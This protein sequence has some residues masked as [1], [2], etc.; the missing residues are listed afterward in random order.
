MNKIKRNQHITWKLKH[1]DHYKHWENTL[2][3]YIV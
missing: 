3:K 1:I 2:I